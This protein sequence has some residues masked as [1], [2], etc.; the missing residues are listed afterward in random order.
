MPGQTQSGFSSLCVIW[1][2]PST[3][4]PHLFHSP[5]ATVLGT[6]HDIVS[7]VDPVGPRASSPRALQLSPCRWVPCLSHAVLFDRYLPGKLIPFWPSPDKCR[8]AEQGNT[9]IPQLT[10]GKGVKVHLPRSSGWRALNNQKRKFHW[11]KLFPF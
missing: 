7:P 11:T 4:P 2:S 3:P 5:S 10:A 8:P 9:L 6:H 1:A